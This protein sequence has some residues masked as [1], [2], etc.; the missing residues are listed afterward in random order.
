MLILKVYQWLW[1]AQSDN[2]GGS[3]DAP[4]VAVD[5]QFEVQVPPGTTLDVST[6]LD[7]RVDVA[8]VTGPISAANVNGPIIV[9]ELH[10]CAVVESVNG[11]VSL[12][13]ARAPSLDCAIDTINGDITVSLPSN[14]GLDVALGSNQ[15]SHGV[16][17]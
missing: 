13:F 10:D 8:G 14:A 9:S 16:R 5:Y 15:W 17:D 2:G 11:S 6:V 7:G 1:A 3:T 12:T 4:V